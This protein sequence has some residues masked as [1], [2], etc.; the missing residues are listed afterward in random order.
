MNESIK[1]PEL[2]AIVAVENTDNGTQL[3]AEET[4]AVVDGIKAGVA[5]VEGKSVSIEDKK[6]ML[7]SA[8]R[9]F[10]TENPEGGSS[11]MVENVCSYLQEAG[12][13]LGVWGFNNDLHIYEFM[14]AI[15]E[16]DTKSIRFSA[17]MHE[18]A[19]TLGN[20]IRY[21]SGEHTL[22]RPLLATLFRV[23]KMT[24]ELRLAIQ[25]AKALQ[26]TDEIEALEREVKEILAQ[27]DERDKNRYYLDFSYK[28]SPLQLHAYGKASVRDTALF[29]REF[30]DFLAIAERYFSESGID[31]KQIKQAEVAKIRAELAALATS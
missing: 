29:R 11:M 5:V 6:H 7:E 15:K 20:T 9:S 10:G 30:L 22:Y 26:M 23:Y 17:I 12:I 27:A 28:M 14:L 25:A 3:G 24:G 31:L 4:Q 13:N 8:L 16:R 2:I 21:V 1:N 18:A 19:R